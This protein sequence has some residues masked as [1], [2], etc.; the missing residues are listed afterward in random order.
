MP[1]SFVLVARMPFAEHNLGFG[2]FFIG[3]SSS[4]REVMVDDDLVRASVFRVDLG[5][6]GAVIVSGS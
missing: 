1:P 4:R 3:T 6:S 5:V 2:H